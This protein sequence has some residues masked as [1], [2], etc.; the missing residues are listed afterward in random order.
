MTNRKALHFV[1]VFLLCCALFIFFSANGQNEPQN[2]GRYLMITP[3]EWDSVL[4]YF[5]NYKREIGFDVQV[6]TTNTTG[7]TVTSI[8]DYIQKQYDI[9]STRPVFV[10]LV[11]DT[12][13]IPAYEGDASGKV[14]KNP[15]SDLG[16]ALLEGNDLFADL[17]L[18]RFS[19]ANE[20]QLQNIIDK[21][22]FM[23]KNMQNF[24]KKAVFI[25][26]DEKKGA[27]NRLYMKNTFKAGHKYVI[28]NSFIPLGFDCK[29]L[30]QPNKEEVINALSDNPL[31]FIYAGHG[32]STS[33]AGNSFDFVQ[34]DISSVTNTIFPVV[35]AFACKTGN[36]AQKC[37]GEH[38]IREKEKGSVAYFGSSVISRT[39]ADPIIEKK[40]LG[41]A[42]KESQSLSEMIN[43]GMKRFA[44]AAGIS[45]KKKEIYIKSYN[46]L[47]DPSLKLPK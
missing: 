19:V 5:A 4:T 17:F 31:F 22:I 37:I 40:I 7:N 27:W 1:R 25:A 14:E 45:K 13:K 11:G 41:A 9:I 3:P 8:K 2:K 38:F 43:L 24:A 34:K 12:D 15:I 21:T 29:R 26:G 32:S 30:E 44:K 47:G 36:F 20:K 16:Y 42:L 10:L 33:L 28:T 35:F 46:L 18:G 39:H 23:E 6:V